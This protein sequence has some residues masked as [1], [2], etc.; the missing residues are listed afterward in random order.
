MEHV[1]DF[2]NYI[3][4]TKC[5]MYYQSVELTKFMIL[6]GMELILEYENESSSQRFFAKS[7][8]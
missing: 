6:L 5:N 8:V 4:E 3:H 2:T 1:K 7:T